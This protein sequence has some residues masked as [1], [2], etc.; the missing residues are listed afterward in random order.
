M[1][2]AAIPRSGRHGT[3]VAAPLGIMSQ[4]TNLVTEQPLPGDRQKALRIVA[5]SV[6]KELKAQGF[7]SGDM[8]GFASAI[9]D[10]VRDDLRT[11]S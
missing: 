3:G 9:V 1:Q 4:R 5:K 11:P 2:S 7:E 10:L 8:V 6:F